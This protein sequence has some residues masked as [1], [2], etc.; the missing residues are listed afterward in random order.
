M[1]YQSNGVDFRTRLQDWIPKLV[2]SPSLAAMLIFVYGFIAWSIRVSLS[3]WKGL[4]PDYT[5]VGLQ[6]YI[7]LFSD[8]RFMIDVRNTVVF[9]TGF[10]IGCIVI[11]LGLLLT[12][13]HAVRARPGGMALHQLHR[14]VG[15]AVGADAVG[16]AR[17]RTRLHDCAKRC[18]SAAGRAGYCA[19]TL[20]RILTFFF[21]DS[22]M[23]RSSAS[24]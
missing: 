6:Q 5:F 9:T 10:L 11:G 12:Q 8:R 24:I 15:R 17:G 7:S 18:A 4:L 22:L 3:K 16:A 2:L 1:A 20:T 23:R 21:S 19:L 14:L 13:G